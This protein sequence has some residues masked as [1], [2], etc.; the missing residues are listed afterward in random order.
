MMVGLSTWWV[1]AVGTTMLKLHVAPLSLLLGGAGGVVA[2]LFCIV[3][4]LETIGQ[5]VNAQSL[6]GNSGRR[7]DTAKGGHGDAGTRGHGEGE[8]RRYGGTETRRHGD[9]ETR[10]WGD[11]ATRR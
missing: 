9:T 1:D 8:T 10:R 4:D 3:L 7:G 2:A 11:W 6:D 5:T